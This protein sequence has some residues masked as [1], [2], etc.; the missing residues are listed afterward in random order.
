MEKQFAHRI[1]AN[2]V[3]W[4]EDHNRPTELIQRDAKNVVPYTQL[5]WCYADKYKIPCL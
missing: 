4:A 2:E 3:I 1:N 5:T